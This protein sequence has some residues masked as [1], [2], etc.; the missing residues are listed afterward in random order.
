MK[1]TLQQDTAAVIAEAQQ[2]VSH[3]RARRRARTGRAD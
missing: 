1:D 2:A 3:S